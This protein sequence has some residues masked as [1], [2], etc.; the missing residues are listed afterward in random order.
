MLFH[1]LKQMVIVS[2]HYLNNNN[3]N[4]KKMMFITIVLMILIFPSSWHPHLVLQPQIV[5]R[6][7]ARYEFATFCLRYF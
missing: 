6:Y 7:F 4:K 1:I 2:K 3:N 5:H